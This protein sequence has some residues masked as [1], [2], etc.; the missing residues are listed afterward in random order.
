VRKLQQLASRT[1]PNSW[2][3]LDGFW[4]NSAGSYETVQY[5]DTGTTGTATGTADAVYAWCANTLTSRREYVVSDKI[6]EYSAGTYTDR[7]NG[8]TVGSL[9]MMCQYGVATICAMGA[10]NPTVFSTGGNFAALAGSPNAEIVLPVAN[11]LLYLNI[12]TSADG[13]ETSDVGDY[14]AY[15]TGE[16]ADGLLNQTPGPITAGVSFGNYAI[17]FKAD[18]I[19]RISYVGGIVKWAT[20]LLYRGVGCQARFQSYSLVSKYMACAGGGVVIF[21][22]YYDSARASSFYYLFDGAS[23]PRH[24]NPLTIVQEGRAFYNPQDDRFTIQEEDLTLVLPGPDEY[25][26]TTHYYS[27]SVDAWGRRENWVSPNG[28]A[29]KRVP[30][31]GDFSAITESSS[32]PVLYGKSA[33]DTLKRY[34]PGNL[35]ASG[36]GTFT[37]TCSLTSS[38]VGEEERKTYFSR[39]IPIIRRRVSGLSAAATMSASFYGERFGS[40]QGVVD[41]S[42]SQ[43]TSKSESTSPRRYDFTGSDNFGQ[44]TVSWTDIWVDVEDFLIVG[45]LAGT[46]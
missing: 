5:H 4:P 27:R 31:L 42:S 11:A 20:E 37:G 29:F 16:A 8:V 40:R 18:A 12:D 30:L 7:T 41:G 44:F 1:D 23:A 35:S 22:G 26:S 32:S 43:T 3:D 39:L 15:G 36:A 19:Y 14:T 28:H 34:A 25:F 9:P 45:K 38:L 17:V 46:K 6:F 33:A 21:P 2:L 10:S 24:I 13:W